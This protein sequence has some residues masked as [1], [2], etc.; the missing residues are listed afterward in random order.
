MPKTRKMNRYK[1]KRGGME[2]AKAAKAAVQG[3][4]DTANETPEE[5]PE[6]TPAEKTGAA[7]EE[8]KKSSFFDRF[9]KLFKFS[10]KQT[11][12]RRRKTKKGRTSKR[13]KKHG[14]RKR[15]TRR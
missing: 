6:E 7:T 3:A 8:V 11:G 1:K 14:R 9:I 10:T 13:T 5:T 2:A 15:K 4:M 12:G